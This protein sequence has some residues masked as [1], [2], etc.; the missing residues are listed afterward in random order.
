MYRLLILFCLLSTVLSA[1]TYVGPSVNTFWTD[2]SDQQST[3]GAGYGFRVDYPSGAWEFN[4]A[5]VHSYQWGD[6]SELTLTGLLGAT[7]GN[8]WL[9]VGGEAGWSGDN[10]AAGLQTYLT[11][12]RG[13][14][15]FKAGA[16]FGQRLRAASSYYGGTYITVQFQL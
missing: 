1:Q 10:P 8:E 5:G 12:V 2:A 4:F 11:T 6:D 13:N 9:H 15:R 16:H 3:L 14:L 7:Y